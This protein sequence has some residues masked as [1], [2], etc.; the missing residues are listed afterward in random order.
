M[1]KGSQHLQP[2]GDHWS[3]QVN[4]SYSWAQEEA[5]DIMDIQYTKVMGMCIIGRWRGERKSYA[6]LLGPSH[7]HASA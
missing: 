4:G 3:E 5:S 6:R 2:A 1:Q 7:R